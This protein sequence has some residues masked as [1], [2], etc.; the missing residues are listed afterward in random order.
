[1]SCRR[2]E[3]YREQK[4]KKHTLSADDAFL[5]SLDR[6]DEEAKRKKE[7]KASGKGQ[8]IDHN[9]VIDAEVL[10]D[11]PSHVHR[12][13]CRDGAGRYQLTRRSKTPRGGGPAIKRALLFS[14]KM[15]G[16]EE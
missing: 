16:R 13:E 4:E 7:L 5:R 2:P 10:P 1:M 3:Q 9:Q 15:D 8:L 12:E 6:L 11:K 14:E